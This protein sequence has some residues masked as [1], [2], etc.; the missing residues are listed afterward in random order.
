LL[1][2]A[3]LGR[4]CWDRAD[5]VRP[6]RVCALM[7]ITVDADFARRVTASAIRFQSGHKSGHLQRRKSALPK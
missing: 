2:L 4:D 5:L 7:T 3:A 6:G 1:P